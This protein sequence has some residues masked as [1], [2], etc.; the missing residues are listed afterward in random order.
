MT[1]LDNSRII[2]PATGTAL[3]AKSWLT[4]APLR[5]LMNNLHPD[6]AERP[7]ELVVYG[8]IG[9]AARDWESFDRIVETR[10]NRERAKFGNLTPEQLEELRTKA[11]A[12]DKM[13]YDLSSEHEKALADAKTQTAA[14]VAAVYVPKL[15]NA[16][17]RAA[18]A[19]RISADDLTKALEFVDPEKFLTDN[20]E[21]IDPA[22][23]TAFIDGIAPAQSGSARIIAPPRQL[24]QGNHQQAVSKPGEAGRAMAQKRFGKSS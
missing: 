18:S 2:K 23:I 16:E 10:L 24:G 20:G 14:D 11:E 19:G 4:E 5:M 21:D 1:R 17:L 13:Q 8:G 9:R 22:K 12:H 15:I 3:S 7:E 6:V